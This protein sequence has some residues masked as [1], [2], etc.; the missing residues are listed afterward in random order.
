MWS[1]LVENISAR[2][3]GP[4]RASSATRTAVFGI[5]LM[6]DMAERGEHH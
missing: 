4:R 3:T 1:A 5:Y 2:W 6:E